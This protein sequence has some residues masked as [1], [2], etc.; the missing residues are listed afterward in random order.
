F[1]RSCRCQSNSRFSCGEICKTCISTFTNDRRISCVR[2]IFPCVQD[3]CS[4]AV[5]IKSNCC[6][7][8]FSSVSI[9]C[10]IKALFSQELFK[11]PSIDRQRHNFS[12]TAFIQQ[13]ITDLQNSFQAGRNLC[14][15]CL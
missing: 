14:D 11:E 7:S 13:L 4:P 3:I 9:V 15:P 8:L 2:K 10:I 6:S 5:L 1:Q 12:G